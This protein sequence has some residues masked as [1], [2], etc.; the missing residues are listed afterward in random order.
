MGHSKILS[1]DLEGH[2]KIR[3][4]KVHLVARKRKRFMALCQKDGFLKSVVINSRS[5]DVSHFD[6]SDINEDDGNPNPS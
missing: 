6:Q 4:D 2:F 5:P 3:P 1:E